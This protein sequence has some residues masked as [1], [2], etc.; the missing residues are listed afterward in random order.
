[1]CKLVVAGPEIRSAR[2]LGDLAHDR[3][4]YQ[5]AG[6]KSDTSLDLDLEH[7]RFALCIV[8]VDDNVVE[9]P[10][11]SRPLKLDAVD[12]SAG[13]ATRLG[14][15]QHG[16]QIIC[17]DLTFKVAARWSTRCRIS[18]VCRHTLSLLRLVVV[19]E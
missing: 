3:P 12:H 13:Q 15:H 11:F 9:R 1:D 5:V 19:N 17:P 14:A 4:E 6:R 10:A 16:Q 8:S 18:S 7:S 2:G